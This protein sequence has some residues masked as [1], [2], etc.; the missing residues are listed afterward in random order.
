VDDDGVL[1]SRY[2][3]GDAGAFGTLVR[4]HSPALFAFLLWRL[5]DRHRAEDVLQDTFLRMLTHL[6]KYRH[7]G[8]LRAWLFSIARNL[9][10]DTERAGGAGVLVSTEQAPGEGMPTVGDLL[11][12]PDSTRPDVIAE[13]REGYAAARGALADLPASQREV[14]L[15]RQSGLTF[16]EVARIQKVPLNTAL[17]RMHDAVTRLRKRLKTE[18]T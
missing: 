8:R 12:A 16:R 15:M 2:L 4:R 5:R 18:E 1:I 13:R 14:F 17:G 3:D 7:S 9:A 6:G 11:P 10:I